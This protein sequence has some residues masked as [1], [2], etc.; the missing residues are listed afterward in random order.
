MAHGNDG[1]IIHDE[2]WTSPNLIVGAGPMT[3]TFKHRHKFEASDDGTGTI[4]Y[5]DGG[6]IEVS[7]DNGMTWQ[8]ISMFGT[9][10]YNQQIGYTGGP[11]PLNARQGYADTN[12]SYPA[13][14]TVTINTAMTLAN[15]T[16]KVRFRIG[17]DD[18]VGDEGW[19]V[20]DVSF[21]GITNTPFTGVCRGF[22]K[23]SAEYAA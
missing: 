10:G 7:Q 15:K 22:D 4:A 17:T 6:V 11:N 13:M 20:D 14:D 19:Y 12:P 3:M 9:P 23:M 16:I 18:F 2:R 5:W 8:D 1:D 21:T